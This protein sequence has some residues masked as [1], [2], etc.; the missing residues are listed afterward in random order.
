[1]QLQTHTVDRG[2][3]LSSVPVSGS[4]RKTER[5][6]GAD[7]VG[8]HKVGQAAGAQNLQGEGAEGREIV[9]AGEDKGKRSSSTYKV[10]IKKLEPGSLQQCM[11]GR[12][13]AID[14]N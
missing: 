11:A 2:K 6:T 4:N 1:M 9:K 8:G 13:E 7:S 3:W 10:I 5:G 12:Q 14:R